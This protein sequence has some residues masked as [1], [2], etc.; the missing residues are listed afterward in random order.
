MKTRKIFFI[1]SFVLIAVGTAFTVF[2][3]KGKTEPTI[4]GFPK[5]STYEKE[6]QRVDSL[7][8]VGLPKSALD[9]V[10]SIYEHATKEVNAAQIVKAIIHRLKF[11]QQVQEDATFKSINKLNEEIAKSS[12]PVTPVLHSVLADIYQQYYTQNRWKF[13][14]RTQVTNVKMDDIST[15]D[16]KTL[17]DQII[18]QHLLALQSADS[19]KRTPLNIYDEIIHKG[20]QDARKLRPTLYDFIAHRA[21]DFL[22]NDEPDVIRPAYKFELK[23]ENY[24][25]TYNEFIKL[26]I[27]SKD[28]LSTKY[29]A[30]LILK[31]LL[32]FHASDKDPA[33]LIDADLKRLYFVK[34]HAIT[35]INDSLY[36][37]AL[38]SLEQKFITHSASSE[39]TYQIAALYNERGMKYNP[40]QSD[41][42]KWFLK[43]AMTICED[44]IKRFPD[45]FG[46]EQCKL[47]QSLI[48]QKNVTFTLEKVTLVNK[49]FRGYLSYRNVKK[50]Y[51]RVISIDYEKYSRR[52]NNYE[53]GYGPNELM[54]EYLQYKPVKEW[55]LELPDDGDFQT[56]N[57]DFKVDELPAGYYVVL[58]SAN[59]AFDLENNGIA[60]AST[61]VSNLSFV[62]RRLQNGSYEFYVLDR[63]TGAPVKSVTANLWYQKYNEKSRRYQSV[64][65]DTQ[66]SDENGRF[67][68]TGKVDYTNFDVELI[69]GTDRY[70]TEEGLYLY[71]QYEGKSTMYSRTILFTDRAIYRPG[72]TIYFKGIVISTDGIKNEILSGH[73]STIT[74][75][76]VNYQ[77]IA[78]L[79]VVTNEYGSFSGQFTVPNGVLNG[80]MSI[81]D[82]NGTVGFS[83]EDYK[84]P[85]FEVNFSPV[86]GVY[87][88][89]D[90]VKV[91]GTA[92]A[93]AG[94]NIDGAEVKYR[95]VRNASFPYWWWCWRGYYPSSPQ[96]EIS[97]GVTTTNDTGGYFINFKAIPDY[98][99]SRES[100]PTY[101]YT[102][103]ADITDIN[104]ETHSA[105][106]YVSVAYKA[107]NISVNVPALVNKEGDKKFIIS[108]SNTNGVFEPSK[109]KVEVYKMKEPSRV[110]RSRL[111]PKADRFLMSKDEY[112]AAFPKDIYADENNVYN[113]ERGEKVFD[114]I[115]NTEKNK[116]LVLEDLNKWKPGMYVMESHTKDKFGEDIKEIIYFTVY[117]E[118]EQVVPGN[119][120]DWFAM[121]KS[122]GEPGEKAVFVIGSREAN[123]NVMYDIE[124][125]GKS[126]KREWITLTN[127][128]K[129]IEIPIEEKHRGNFCIHCVFV[130]NGRQYEHTG[131]VT[132]PWT[133]K[134][135]G[136]EFE[137]FRNKLIPGQKEEWKIKIKDKKGDKLMAE[138][139]ATVYDAS[140]DAFQ[141][142]GWDFNIYQTYYS[143]L[144]WEDQLAF[145]TLNSSLYG[146]YWNKYYSAI[147][148]NYD[149]LNW[150]G[151]YYYNYYN[152]RY[153]YGS[154]DRA[155]NEVAGDVE[156]MTIQAADPVAK[157][158]AGEEKDFK[159]RSSPSVITGRNSQTEATPGMVNDKDG[160]L[161]ANTGTAGGKNKGKENGEIATRKNFNETAF[162]Y[163]HLQT[164]EQGNVIIKF[165]IPEALTRWKMMGLAHTKD[166][167]YGQISR[168]FVTQKELMVVPNAP[169][170][171]RENDVIEF[172]AKVSNLSSKDLNGQA[173]LFL[174][175][176][177]TMKDITSTVQKANLPTPGGS[178]FGSQKFNVVKGLSTSLSWNLI[179]PEGVG[180]IT[181]KVVAR[182]DEFSDGEE[183]AIP[184]L[185]NRMLVTESMPLPIRSKQTKVFKFDKLISQNAG[186][187][188]LRNHK[189][190]LEFTSNPAWY[191]VQS[192]P[193]L[194]EYPYECAEQT[195][196]RYYAN[197]IAAHIANSSP[198][199]KAVFESWKSK[200]PDALLSNLEKNQELKSLMLEETP[201]VLDAKS[202]T[203]RKK[204]VALL[205]D[206]N[207]MSNELDRAF[208]K[209]E[210]MQLS[211]GGWP[212]FDNM[213]DDRYITQHIITGMGHLDH[214][215]VKNVREDKKSWKMVKNGLYYLDDRIRE[216]Y[217]SILK[218]GHPEL[219]NIGYEQI[220]YLY[221]RSY[222]KDVA[223]DTRNQKAFD[224]FKGQA[225]QFWN[226]KGRYMQGMI[227]LALNRYG[228]KTIPQKIMK[229]L[230]ETSLDNEEMGM[231]WKE[232]YEGFYWWEAPIEA[233]ALL[234]EAFDEV[235]ND[236]K[237]VDDLKVWLLKSKQTQNWQTTKATTEA[238]YAL[239]LRGTDWL[240]T[241][242]QVEISMGNVKV[243][244]KQLP[245]VKVEAGTGYFKT[246]WSGADI[247]PEMGTVTVVKKDEGVSWGAVYWQY[248]EQLDKITPAKT[249]LQLKKK[250]FVER[251]TESGPVLESIDGKKALKVGDKLK[252]RIELRVDRDMQYVHM[253]D[254]R[255][256]GFEP[257]NVISQYKWQD[258]LGYY[259]STR[260]AATNFFI[261]YLSKGTYVFEYPLRVTH[262]GDFSNGI[263]SI[264][265]MYA[266][267]FASHSEG[268]RVK[269]GK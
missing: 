168:E 193:Y 96:M 229:S 185:T 78:S 194:M 192:L 4:L 129:R 263:T 145:G 109:G 252:V 44:A 265:C 83:V 167:K 85:K 65:S 81:S 195:F 255:A 163:P 126:V 107:L 118:K 36:L 103:Y 240:A 230:K 181:Y 66:V 70:H 260:D 148:R 98:S 113:W 55:T 116:E 146:N 198:K 139:M 147:T 190:T 158:V 200:T 254:M 24:F 258:G 10:N 156:D 26:P 251:N 208:N 246:S 223:I 21:L 130:K 15:W 120:P 16:L 25:G 93:Y 48:Q 244:P 256:S 141:A 111:W 173:Q 206:L 160:L 47:L 234:I 125:Q 153:M 235:A 218:Y 164:D 2:S 99:I 257:M 117:S 29:Y 104:G 53:N 239:L 60:Y 46:A 243:D 210:K 131:L 97:N 221:A 266:P 175:D 115:F 169:R 74:F 197:S 43:K 186:S 247:K 17:F 238:C 6:W 214:L 56:H 86:K 34:L 191:A 150:F 105:Q 94:S 64:K 57:L 119:E 63:E 269:V 250:L 132:V 90:E 61:W 154:Y 133:N 101:T 20:T 178:G 217:E 179:I 32:A 31:D 248:F 170:F 80:Y 157:S 30:T 228:D 264:E 13:S 189:L 180:A 92:K 38:Q 199:I 122:S 174:Y 212:W 161:A 12:Y 52:Y 177:I 128:Q 144:N 88:L 134:E 54:K 5:G 209:L 124:E 242:S 69:K 77:K 67:V 1:T 112:Y 27:S 172:T 136:L 155:R 231:Y 204:R 28:T 225:Q 51:A 114:N 76:D 82:P 171:F 9:I 7:T 84:R 37:K 236:K 121:V 227:A 49:P 22:M 237:S 262:N 232:N 249:P 108:T 95:V 143:L 182:A 220:Q 100:S 68:V 226:N 222:F 106:S 165:T 3:F 216:D 135:L 201:W 253:K 14:Q 11:E 19:L 35:G 267:E 149:Q 142:H 261:S 87:R 213:P 152:S 140:L 59:T 187:S 71:R 245:D 159:K 62:N 91:D 39:V 183:M 79:N 202:E 215:G 89:E 219:D 162:F 205:F 176:A 110:F 50:M 72:Q 184:V 268:I 58:L 138:M 241:E 166:L 23:G 259:E 18:K 207:H 188:T 123:V 196:S 151:Y 33:A 40:L 45:S 8:S 211:N 102:V 137:T 203:E 224:Y 73:A 75:S 41:Q 127:E 42:N 233:Q